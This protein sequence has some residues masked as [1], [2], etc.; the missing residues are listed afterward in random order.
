MPGKNMEIFF[1]PFK[2]AKP[3]ALSPSQGPYLCSYEVG[4]WFGKRTFYHFQ[5]IGNLCQFKRNSQ[6]KEFSLIALACK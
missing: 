6:N 5:N 3:D 2:I 4:K 1:F